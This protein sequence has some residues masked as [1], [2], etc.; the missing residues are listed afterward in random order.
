MPTP[1]SEKVPCGA[2]ASALGE[3][4]RAR[5]WEA[6]RSTQERVLSLGPEVMP[7]VFAELAQVQGPE[8]F[9]VLLRLVLKWKTAEDV[10][11]L[12]EPGEP[13]WCLRAAL[14]EALA[15]YAEEGSDPQLRTRIAQALAAL[16]TDSDVG[17]R[18]TAVEAIGRGRL[19]AHEGAR[20]RLIELA[21]SDP[22][23]SVREEAR[24]VLTEID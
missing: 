4:D 17:V 8:R 3:F 24:H 18:I 12:L 13:S 21:A 1:M 5:G 11:A 6:F 19:A 7:D 23:P 10:L 14:A 9:D 15:Y 2:L 16:A 20:A 22:S